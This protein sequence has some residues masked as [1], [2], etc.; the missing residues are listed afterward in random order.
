MRRAEVIA[1]LLAVVAAAF[2][3][4]AGTGPLAA[5]LAALVLAGLALRAR[6]AHYIV[7]WAVAPL[8]VWA[9][10]PDPSMLVA[11]GALAACAIVALLSARDRAAT[12]SDVVIAS[13]ITL[14]TAMVVAASALLT[15]DL[16][17]R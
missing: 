6:S 10:W 12:A 13:R 15:F 11:S 5:G 1:I 9:T 16:L 3:L 14:A 4:S 7:V 2:G 17:L 8:L